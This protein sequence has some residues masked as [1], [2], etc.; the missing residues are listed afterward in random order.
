M[1]DSHRTAPEARSWAFFGRGSRFLLAVLLLA[2]PAPGRAPEGRRPPAYLIL[3][4]FQ[5]GRSAV[6]TYLQGLLQELRKGGSLTADL[7]VEYLDLEN[8]PSDSRPAL[9]ALL[10]K[11]YEGRSLDGLAILQRPAL[12]FY[13]RELRTVAPA[14]PVLLANAVLQPGELAGHPVLTQVPRFD[15]EG[16][17][18]RGLELFPRT[19]RLVLVS[20]ASP[21]DRAVLADTAQLLMNRWRGRLELEDTSGLTLSQ[22]LA[23]VRSLPPESLI[24]PLS[25][26]RDASG[27]PFLATEVTERVGAVANAPMMS[28]IDGLPGGL[29]GSVVVLGESGALAGRSLLDVVTGR[30]GLVA[31]VTPLGSVT[32]N[33]FDWPRLQRWKA[34]L[35]HLPKDSHFLHRP[36]SLWQQ[37]R[38]WAI[39]ALAFLLGQS[40]LIVVL[41][42]QRRLRRAAEASLQASEARF[43][44][45]IE[46]APVAI[47]VMRGGTFLYVNRSL[48]RSCG[49]A[50]PALLVGRPVLE[51]LVAPKDRDWVQRRARDREAGLPVPPATEFLAQRADGTSFPCLATVNRVD[52]SDGHALL[53]FFLDLSEQSQAEAERTKLEEQL[54]QSQKLEA[55]GLLAGGVAHDINNVLTAIFSHCEILKLG[56]SEQAFEMR[57]IREIERAASRSKGIVAQLLAFSRKQVTQPEV[58]DLNVRLGDVRQ[59]LIPLIG[60]DIRLEVRPDPNLWN[61][62]MDPTQL[63]QILVNLAV[64]ARD[65]MPKGGRLSIV[66]D[67]LRITPERAEDYPDAAPGDYV[68]IQVSDEGV[69]MSPEVRARI[70]EPFF[71]TKEVGKGTGLGL[72]TVFGIVRQ[73]GGFLTVYSEPGRGTTFKVHFPATRQAAE[74]EAKP[75]LLQAVPHR[76]SVL[77]VEDDPLLQLAIPPMLELIGCEVH[78]AEDPHE[79]LD[80]FRQEDPPY[81]LVL[82]DVVMPGM[83]G[84]ELADRIHEL[85]PSTRILLMSGYTADVI[86][87]HSVF[88][89]TLAFIQKPFTREALQ[90]KLLAVMGAD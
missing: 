11:K 35:S 23:R 37:Y 49:F 56:R 88:G 51:T 80:M 83:S 60:E 90:E 29:G 19:R 21:V 58:L 13:E 76:W 89:A 68:R 50:D 62:L 27:A 81:D 87:R 28:Y 5:P 67:N 40:A 45:L 15:W 25:Y 44:T 33:V 2:A 79:A 4:S 22:T 39:G 43:R 32:R 73:A 30:Q 7:C 47:A 26:N 63:D 84:K 52:L 75:S 53:G 65:A 78:L 41:L 69:G 72:S 66:A 36:P 12:D 77:V 82:T 54:R 24:L 16:I 31:P 8:L 1:N 3:V 46:E 10:R 17:V 14:A 57:S 38:G 48:S 85:R 59:G 42:V 34:D 86:E 71:T 18:R 6:E 74:A 61:V 70:F 64:N 20:G 55:V 9:G